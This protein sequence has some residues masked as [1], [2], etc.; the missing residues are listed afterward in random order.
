[1]YQSSLDQM[2]LTDYFKRINFDDEARPDLTTLIALHKAHQNAVPFE[3]IDVQLGRPL[4]LNVEESYNKIVR[5]H[6]GGWCYE[7]NGLMGWVLEEIGFSVARLSAGVMREVHGD[8]KLGNHLCLL[9]QLDQPY[10]VDVGFGGSLIAP[11]PLK[12]SELENTP[13]IIRLK[14]VDGDFWRFS[15]QAYGE[16]FSFDF[17][18]NLRDEN[19]LAENIQYQQSSP[20]SPFVQ[21]LVVQRR[22]DDKHFSLRGR[23]LTSKT[24]LGEDK[25][26]LKS[27]EHL[28]DVL[29]S[30]FDLNVP[31]ITSLWQ[32]ICTRHK[33][34]FPESIDT[35]SELP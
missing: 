22:Q 14:S 21:N 5:H 23:V 35:Y 3:N 31:E 11:I 17:N 19:L 10:L 7:M 15:E 28:V 8:E 34:L 18:P 33:Q 16:P 20:N 30:Y 1:M 9:V 29:M 27:P 2:T 12:E 24:T 4:T 6:R 26:I 25:Q 13:Y 32:A